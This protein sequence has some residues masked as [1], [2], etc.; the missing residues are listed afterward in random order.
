MRYR[1]TI[2][3]LLSCLLLTVSSSAQQIHEY[4]EEQPLVIVCDWEF[5]PYEFNNDKGQPDG[6]NVEVLDLIL[7]RLNI[8]HR[9][10]MQE[11]YMATE[12]FEKREADLI[13]ALSFLFKQRP[14]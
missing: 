8:P 12:T 11:W 3:T 9:Y 14:Y 7:N 1:P 4:T 6:Y 2:L 13:H 5:P 10:L